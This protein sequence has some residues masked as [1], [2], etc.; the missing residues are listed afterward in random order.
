MLEERFLTIS[1]AAQRL[2]VTRG[3]VWQ[4]VREGRLKAHKIHPRLSLIR[5]EDLEEFAKIK[6][7]NGRPPKN[8]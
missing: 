7:R 5:E 3:R 8:S 2:G 6:R 4:F 1:E